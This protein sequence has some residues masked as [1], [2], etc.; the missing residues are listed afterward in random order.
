MR[1]LEI[2]RAAYKFFSHFDAKQ[3]RQVG[4]K[5][6]SLLLH[7][8]PADCS[9]LKGYD[10]RHVDVGEFR[11]VYRFDDEI[12][13][14]ILI[15]KRTDDEVYKDLECK[16]VLR[17]LRKICFFNHVF[18]EDNVPGFGQFAPHNIEDLRNFGSISASGRVCHAARR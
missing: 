9:K 18:A 10:Y 3:Y 11:I 13:Y 17:D 7:P 6:F 8:Q 4:K 15:G 16:L 14:V 12:V 1:K 5:V 2:E